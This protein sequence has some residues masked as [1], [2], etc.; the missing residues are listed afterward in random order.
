MTCLKRDGNELVCKEL[1][2][3][4]LILGATGS[5]TSF[6]GVVGV[7]CQENK[8]LILNWTLCSTT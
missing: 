3:T 1:F 5:N 8:W 7:K 6:S 2:I 4:E